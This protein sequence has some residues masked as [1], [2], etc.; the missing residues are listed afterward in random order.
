MYFNIHEFFWCQEKLA[1]ALP[2]VVVR[3][4]SRNLGGRGDSFPNRSAGWA[5]LD[6]PVWNDC[7]WII[8]W[9]SM[10]VQA[11][12][13]KCL[14]S[15]YFKINFNSGFGSHYHS[16]GVLLVARG[17]TSWECIFF[18]EVYVVNVA[19]FSTCSILK[20]LVGTIKP[21]KMHFNKDVPISRQPMQQLLE[22]HAENIA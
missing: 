22:I 14:W 19:H 2:S 10:F 21:W 20:V 12:E 3:S 4:K 5:F 18:G 6:Y 1:K 9:L 16:I 17:P 15:P 7:E 11:A 13:L 8:T